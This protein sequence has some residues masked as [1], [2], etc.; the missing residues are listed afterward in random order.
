[1]I[2]WKYLKASI[3]TNEGLEDAT[4]IVVHVK[5]IRKKLMRFGN[6]AIYPYVF[7]SIQEYLNFIEKCL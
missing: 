1:M 2:H 5:R 4:D 7:Y 6:T 3:F